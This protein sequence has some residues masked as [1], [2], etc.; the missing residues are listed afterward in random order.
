MNLDEYDRSLDNLPVE[1]KFAGLLYDLSDCCDEVCRE[2]DRLRGELC[3]C[4]LCNDAYRLQCLLDLMEELIESNLHPFRRMLQ[5][6]GKS[7]EEI[8][9]T[10]AVWAKARADR[11]AQAPEPLVVAG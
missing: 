5:R 7:E 11:A 1:E 2:H 8:A 10:E 4:M 3:D 9:D 6:E